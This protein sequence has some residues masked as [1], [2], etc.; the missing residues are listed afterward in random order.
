MTN[1][2]MQDQRINDIMIRETNMGML[3]LD[4]KC[5]LVKD[6]QKD[7]HR[8]TILKEMTIQTPGSF[9]LINTVTVVLHLLANRDILGILIQIHR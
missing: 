8:G 6:I 1:S 7:L 9:T 4:P 5:T 2:G 3:V